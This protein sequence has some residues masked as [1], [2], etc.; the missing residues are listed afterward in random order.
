MVLMVLFLTSLHP[1][2]STRT[3]TLFPTR[4]SSG[5]R[6]GLQ[7]VADQKAGG[8]LTGGALIGRTR[9]PLLPAAAA[10]G[11][12]RASLYFSAMNEHAVATQPHILVVDD[13]TS[14]RGLLQRY[15]SDQGFRVTT[16]V[17]AADARAKP[18]AHTFALPAPDTTG[19]QASREQG[20][21]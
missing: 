6:A 8:A 1:P 21:T 13:D 7:A 19:Q 18:A 2:R 12:S 5:L 10:G 16:A 4:R 3:Y 20:V 9:D 15:L 11:P 14:L 17:D